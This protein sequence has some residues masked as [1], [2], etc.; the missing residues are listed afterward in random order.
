MRL[1]AIVANLLFV[2]VMS[3]IFLTERPHGMMNWIVT[4]LAVMPSL[5]S[6]VY[7]FGWTEAVK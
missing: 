6:L 3:L 1:L 4:A 7:I 2:I 5:I